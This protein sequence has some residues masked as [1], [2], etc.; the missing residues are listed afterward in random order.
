MFKSLKM[1]RFSF[2][3]VMAFLSAVA[4]LTVFVAGSWVF[5][6][7]A[8]R[9]IEAVEAAA[10]VEKMEA[11]QKYL[12]VLLPRALDN[13]VWDY[14]EWDDMYA[15]CFEPNEDWLEEELGWQVEEGAVN[16]RPLSRVALYNRDAEP[17]YTAG[18]KS[19]DF[20]PAVKSVLKKKEPLTGILKTDKAVYLI[21]VR[22]V[23]RSDGS[24]PTAGVLAAAQSL[25]PDMVSETEEVLGCKISFMGY[26]SLQHAPETGWR[27]YGDGK[28]FLVLSDAVIAKTPLSDIMGK[29]V[30]ELLVERHTHSMVL[31]AN[32][33][34]AAIPISTAGALAVLFVNLAVA[35]MVTEPVASIGRKLRKMEDEERLESIGPVE[36]PRE[37]TDLARLFDKAVAAAETS[38][39]REKEALN[40]LANSDPLTGLANR[41]KFIE[42]TYQAVKD[43]ASGGAP[44][45][46]IL[47]DLNGLK[48]VNDSAGHQTGDAR[49]CAFASL[50]ERA[51]NPAR[52][53][54]AARIGGDEF[55]LLFRG[56][57]R[58]AEFLINAVSALVSSRS[59]PGDEMLSGTPPFEAAVASYPQDGTTPEA[60]L[61]AADDALKAKKGGGAAGQIRRAVA[62]LKKESDDTAAARLLLLAADAYDRYTLGHS[63]RVSGL[64]EAVARELGLGEDRIRRVKL[65]GLFHDIG[66]ALLPPDLL[67]KTGPLNPEEKAEIES[68]AERGAAL[69]AACPGLSDIAPWV[70]SHHERLDGSGYPEGLKDGE[71]PLES[72]ILAAADAFDAMTSPRLHHTALSVE[73][74]LEELSNSPGF[75]SAVVAA[76]ARI[77]ERR[78]S[79][80]KG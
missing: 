12:T 29:S 21:S 42:E 22:P 64:A 56:T 3:A 11:V 20:L 57:C 45:T 52:G 43:A 65:A 68:H 70:R 80:R 2:R 79:V 63:E 54:V 27:S 48:V 71:I 31:I 1:S 10:T 51:C 23:H 7:L 73:K 30:G 62:V 15:Q 47:F 41:R 74:A 37:I 4:C 53:D 75:D 33:P 39:R 18:G 59:L 76:L 44:T 38:A 14:A 78:N 58:E 28:M 26:G 36:G 50:L 67:S 13:L 8:W 5:S 25:S 46:V 60:L 17:I 35:R 61:E 6:A 40:K 24:G 9:G 32:S 16:G 49:I 77:V 72:R 19:P 66:K 69:L 55:A 34:K